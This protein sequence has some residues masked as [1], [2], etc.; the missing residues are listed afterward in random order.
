MKKFDKYLYQTSSEVFCSSPLENPIAN[1][2]N[3]ATLSFYLTPD[4]SDNAEGNFTRVINK[5]SRNRYSFT[6]I[7]K[8]LW[9][10]VLKHKFATSE[11]DEI[12]LS[13]A[14]QVTISFI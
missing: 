3:N 11:A 14:R 4:I 1:K 8:D 10:L 2:S 5:D 7:G 6:P 13:R 12:L 9:A